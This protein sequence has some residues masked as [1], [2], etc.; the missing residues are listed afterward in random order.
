MKM[1]Q[2]LAPTVIDGAVRYPLEGSISVSDA[3][4]EALL[5]DKKAKEPEGEDDDGLDDKKVAE[6]KHIAAS[7]S[8]DLGEAVKK[9]DIID[10]IR[11][12]RSASGAQ[13]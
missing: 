9:E 8:I 13:E 4:A 3:H 6:L 5:A 7:E 10:K 2:L 12:A 1:I 11:E